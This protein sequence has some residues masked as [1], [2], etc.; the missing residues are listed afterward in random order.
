MS[1]YAKGEA[2]G[3]FEALL[4]RLPSARKRAEQVLAEANAEDDMNP[5][6]RMHELIALF[7][8]LSKPLPLVG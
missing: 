1:G 5:S 4:D 8:S 6:T 2:E 7:E 3:L